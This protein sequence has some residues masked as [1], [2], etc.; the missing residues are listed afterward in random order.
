MTVPGP[1]S[2]ASANL[3]TAQ[4]SHERCA[5]REHVVTVTARTTT[6]VATDPGG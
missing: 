3:A 4:S 5:D 1:R 2:Q 6:K